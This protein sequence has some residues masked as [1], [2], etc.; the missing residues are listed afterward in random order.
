MAIQA[1]CKT[2]PLDDNHL[3]L[4]LGETPTITH[5]FRGRSETWKQVALK[6][7]NFQGN[8]LRVLSAGCSRG[9]EAFSIAA[10]ITQVRPDL[11]FEVVGVDNSPTIIEIAR[12]ASLS[13]QI[14]RFEKA[15]VDPVF[16][17]LLDKMIVLSDGLDQLK[18]S[19]CITNK[20][21]FT[22]ADLFDLPDKLGHFDV[23]MCCNVKMYCLSGV[24]R[25]DLDCRLSNILKAEGLYITDPGYPVYKPK[26]FDLVEDFSDTGVYHKAAKE[27]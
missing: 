8:K 20:C 13:T 3:R 17:P 7:K 16:I 6:A 15:E 22:Q 5:F 1:E 12:N 27:I 25:D 4:S 2:E 9:F 11:D 21:D 14:L 23:I 26:Y 19:P 10:I 24:Q 18:I